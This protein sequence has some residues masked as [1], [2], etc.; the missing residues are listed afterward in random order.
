MMNRIIAMT[1]LRKRRKRSEMT[2][3]EARQAFVD[4]AKAVERFG[5]TSD[6]SM[7]SNGELNFETGHINVQFLASGNFGVAEKV[8]EAIRIFKGVKLPAKAS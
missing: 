6:A 2:V 8:F 1:E 5:E 7:F 3:E 4:F